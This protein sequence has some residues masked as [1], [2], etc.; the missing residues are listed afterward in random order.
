VR[1]EVFS[2]AGERVRTLVDEPLAPGPHEVRWDDRDE[3]GRA[4]APGSYVMRLSA[5]QKS[6]TRRVVV[7]P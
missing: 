6:L 4:V 1:L 3:G 5:E 2:V 7:A